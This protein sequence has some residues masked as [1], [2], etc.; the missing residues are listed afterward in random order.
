MIKDED[1]HSQTDYSGGQREAAHRVLIEIMNILN[2]YKDDILVV[3]GWVPDLY[4]PGEDHI[5]SI[6]V[7]ILLNHLNLEEAAYFTIE[8]ILIDNG[9]RKDKEKYF[10][11]VKSV[12]VDEIKYD[13]D[14]DI[15]AGKYGGTSE[16]KQSQHIQGLKALKATG[17]NFA[18]EIPAVEITIEA[19]R[20][21][22]AFDTG[23]I[24]VVSIVPFLAMKAAALGRGKAKDAYDIYF[25]IKHFPGGV[26][27]LVKDFLP[28]KDHGLVKEMI[29]KLKEK[30]ATPNHAGPKDVAD[31]QELV[32][33]EEIEIVKRDAFEQIGELLDRLL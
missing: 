32:D 33:M 25:C 27:E 21:D 4:F 24:K 26:E 23:R 28:Y 13:V 5:G 31:F 8:K 3:G 18:F 22:G 6:D 7:D 1:L 9:Y 2:A 19:R 17:G 12:V 14:L 29:R 20:P 15:L 16:R 30:F 11:F 10:T